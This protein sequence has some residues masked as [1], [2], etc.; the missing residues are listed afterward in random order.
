MTEE[1]TFRRLKRL[2]FNVLYDKWLKLELMTVQGAAEWLDMQG[3]TDAEFE[4]ELNNY[5][6]SRHRG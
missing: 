6:Y 5:L 1:D 4:N 3:W 2:P